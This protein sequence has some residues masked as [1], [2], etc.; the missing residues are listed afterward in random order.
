M[1]IMCRDHEGNE[2]VIWT[3][4]P[5]S[6]GTST[7]LDRRT[8]HFHTYGIDIRDESYSKCLPWA[9][10]APATIPKERFLTSCY[11]ED[12]ILLWKRVTHIEYDLERPV[13][14]IKD[15]PSQSYGAAGAPIP[16]V[17]TPTQRFVP[18]VDQPRENDGMWL[19]KEYLDNFY[20]KSGDFCTGTKEDFPK[21]NADI[22]RLLW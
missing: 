5:R 10:D 6:A 18:Y 12:I 9:S 20:P 14:R 7:W 22:E 16:P 2:R 3:T 17:Y 19:L 4:V 15:A 13:L 21:G 11:R 8:I 1:T